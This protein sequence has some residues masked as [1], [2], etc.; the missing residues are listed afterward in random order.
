M[1][2]SEAGGDDVTVTDEDVLEVFDAME[3]PAAT[4]SNV[5]NILGCSTETAHRHLETLSERGLVKRK[6]AGSVIMWWRPRKDVEPPP[7]VDGPNTNA[8][9]ETEASFN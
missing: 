2:D 6:H 9:E 4:T 8:L 1:S 5:A 7:P 3:P